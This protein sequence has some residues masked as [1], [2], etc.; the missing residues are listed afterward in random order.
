MLRR[1]FFGAA[2]LP[3]LA[4]PA[5]AQSGNTDP[6]AITPPVET[7]TFK[8]TRLV[9]L[10]TLDP[11]LKLDIRYA[12]PDNFARRAV[13]TQARAFLQRDAARALVRAHRRARKLGYGFTIFDG[14]RPWAVTKLFWDITPPAQ[15]DFVARPSKGSRH[16]RG[17]AVDLTLHDLKTGQQVTMPSPY[18]DFT[19]KASPAYAGGTAGQ[20]RLR[21]LLRTLMERE[22][23]TVFDNEWWH[24]DYKDWRKYPIGTV[25]FEAL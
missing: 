8:K 17:C 13:Y 18:D 20:R 9:E 24:F 10:I 12:T 3:L 4:S 19:D 11:G 2:L 15:R 25:A 1:E 16:N 6:S 21:D 14:Y 5:F 7:G 22:G 23:F